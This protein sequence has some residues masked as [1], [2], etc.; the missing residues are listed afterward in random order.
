MLVVAGINTCSAEFNYQSMA[1]VL[2]PDSVS[3]RSPLEVP[4]PTGMT[5]SIVDADVESV[6]Y[7]GGK[8]IA[9]RLTRDLTDLHAV[10]LESIEDYKNAL[11]SVVNAW[12][13]C[14]P[15]FVPG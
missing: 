14:P 9:D 6:Y 15:I 13:D 1:W 12:A 2:G 7:P 8:V 11:E 4:Q 5:W 10:G 3:I